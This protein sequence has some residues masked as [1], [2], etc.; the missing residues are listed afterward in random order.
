MDITRRDWQILLDRVSKLE[1]KIRGIEA[2]IDAVDKRTRPEEM[3]RVVKQEEKAA[4]I[5]EAEKNP[6]I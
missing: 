2:R 5:R 1:T 4:M 6:L 3:Y